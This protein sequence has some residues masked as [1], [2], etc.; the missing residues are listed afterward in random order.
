MADGQRT[1]FRT[2]Y[3]IFTFTV[4]DSRHFFCMKL[5]NASIDNVSGGSINVF[6]RMWPR[7][8]S[9]FASKR[10]SSWGD[11]FKENTTF[12][13][14]ARRANSQVHSNITSSLYWYGDLTVKTG[15]NRRVC[16]TVKSCKQKLVQLRT[17][18]LILAYLSCFYHSPTHQKAHTQYYD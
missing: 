16:V 17:R 10:P 18:I 8:L 6:L 7:C 3:Y 12:R 13:P 4:E 1:E 14:L 5:V 9:K 2:K 15:S 11:I